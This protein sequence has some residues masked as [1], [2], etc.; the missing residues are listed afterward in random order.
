MKEVAP[1][2]GSCATGTRRPS[3]PKVSV[4]IPDVVLTNKIQRWIQGFG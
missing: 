2:A 4:P 3:E 1:L